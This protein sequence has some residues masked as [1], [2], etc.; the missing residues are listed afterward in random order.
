MGERHEHAARTIA[1]GLMAALMAGGCAHRPVNL[2]RCD[3]PLETLATP[4]PTSAGE[5]LAGVAREMPVASAYERAISEAMAASPSLDAVSAE[6]A[7]LMLSGGSQNGAFGAGFIDEWRVLG[8]TLPE[9]RVVTGISTGAL[10]G[11]MVFTGETGRAVE[12]YSIIRESEILDVQARSALGA[13]RKGAFGTLV[14]LRARIDRLLDT[15][16]GGADDDALLGLVAAAAANRRKFFVGVVDVREGEAMA[17]DM[18]ALAT[19]WASAPEPEKRLIKRC[20]IE[21]LIASSSVPLAAPPVYIDGRMLVDGGV[22]FGVFR[23]AEQAAMARANSSAPS[24]LLLNTRWQVAAECPFKVRDGE[25]CAVSGQPGAELRDWDALTLGLRSVDLLSNQ[26]ARFSVQAADS[27]RIE[28]L[29][30][31]A[32][33]HSFEGKSC[34]DWRA[35]DRATKPVPVQF[36]PKEMRCLIDYGRARARVAR[37]WEVR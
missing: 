24:F 28:R 25:V 29:G 21:T 3:L 5:G 31:D 14:P 37:W 9:F 20:Y 35:E 15:V 1:F 17:V 8:S 33:N 30:A 6:P 4:E 27:A 16:P 22:R 2:T 26:V 36:H 10:I 19:R 32:A 11:T 18:T 7:V 12:G 34:A 23:A 13:A